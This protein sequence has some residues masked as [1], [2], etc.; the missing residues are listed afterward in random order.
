M[1]LITQTIF[2]IF[3]A[4]TVSTCKKYVGDYDQNYLGEWHSETLISDGEEKEVYLKI[5]GKNSQ[6]G[7]LCQINCTSCNCQDLTKGKAVIKKDGS[8]LYVG[9]GG[10]NKRFKL[11]IK[12]QPYQ[13]AN[14]TWELVID[15]GMEIILRKA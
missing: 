1:R 4:L 9:G 15:F 2:L 6:F 13:T 10:N 11:K 7:F 8:V 3:V 12:K 14:G 5:D